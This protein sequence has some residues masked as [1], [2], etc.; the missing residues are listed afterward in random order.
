[1]FFT[2]IVF[3]CWTELEVKLLGIREAT[4]TIVGYVHAHGVNQEECLLDI[5]NCVRT[6]WSSTSIVG[7][8]WP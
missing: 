6:W 5:P 4:D 8:R 1:L 7:R 3:V 2:L